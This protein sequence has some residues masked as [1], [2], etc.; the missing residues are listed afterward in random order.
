MKKEEGSR[1]WSSSTILAEQED[2][3]EASELGIEY[4][5]L[6]LLTEQLGSEETETESQAANSNTSR[7]SS[8]LGL[9]SN[10]TGFNSH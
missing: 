1:S 4:G 7:N 6:L 2:T 5:S 9:D 10:A 8:L 3:L